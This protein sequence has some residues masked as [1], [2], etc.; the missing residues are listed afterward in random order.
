MCK[1]GIVLIPNVLELDIVAFSVN[2]LK[3]NFTLYILRESL[4]FLTTNAEKL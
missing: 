1:I 2:Y 4:S 3:K